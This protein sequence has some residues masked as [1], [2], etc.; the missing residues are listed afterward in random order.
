MTDDVSGLT[1]SIKGSFSGPLTAASTEAS[2]VVSCVDG[3]Q[4]RVGPTSPRKAIMPLQ[5]ALAACWSRVKDGPRTR[6]G[7][8]L[9]LVAALQSRQADSKS[10]DTLFRSGAIFM[11]PVPDLSSVLGLG[12]LPRLKI[13][14][15]VAPRPFEDML[16]PIPDDVQKRFCGDE[17]CR[18]LDLTEPFDKV[19]D[20]LP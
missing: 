3:S 11:L 5:K 13:T 12:T 1:I 14:M 9:L 16:E 17:G 18:L 7:R 20:A 4:T 15:A 2:Y 10:L 6:M 8:A 19:V